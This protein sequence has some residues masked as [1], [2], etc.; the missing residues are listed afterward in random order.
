VYCSHSPDT[1]TL[2][3][4]NGQFVG[5]VACGLTAEGQVILIS[6]SI[7]PCDLTANKIKKP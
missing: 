1:P 7:G 6:E 3:L 4:V 5:G 2:C